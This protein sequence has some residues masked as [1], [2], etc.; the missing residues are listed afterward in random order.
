[1]GIEQANSISQLD[2]QWDSYN[3]EYRNRL[4]PSGKQVII[5]TRWS[6]WDL[7]GRIKARIESGEEHRRWNVLTIP[8]ECLSPHDPLNRAIGERLWPEWFTGQMVAE[9]KSDPLLWSALYQQEPIDASGTW[10][11][12]QYIQTCRHDELPAHLRYVT[13]VDLAL[14]EGSGDYTAI[15][16]AGL[17]ENRT[18][19]VVD[20]R[21]EKVP[22]SR[23]LDTLSAVV[24]QYAPSAVLIEDSPAER[25]FVEAARE[26]CRSGGRSIALHTMPTRGR[27]KETRAAAIR[28]LFMEGRVKL[29]EAQWN[30]QAI[31]QLLNFPPKSRT[32]HDDFVDAAG[33]LGRY[34]GK[35]GVQRDVEDNRYYP[36]RFALQTLENGRIYTT[37]TLDELFAENSPSRRRNARI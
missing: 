23:T 14:T 1:V 37:A 5:S 18:L 15:V 21:L 29:L 8:M 35:L 9:N 12:P 33:L 26:Y 19:Y 4:L 13:S 36:P 22:V 10:L 24:E 7:I 17:S 11:D 2:K 28:S 6:Q 27:D 3:Y 32:Q 34:M 31:R 16:T 25:V 20:V 30:D